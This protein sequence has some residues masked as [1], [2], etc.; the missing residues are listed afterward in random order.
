MP[1][2]GLFDM[3]YKLG[4]LV[5][6]GGLSYAQYFTLYTGLQVMFQARYVTPRILNAESGQVLSADRKIQPTDGDLVIRAPVFSTQVAYAGHP[7]FVFGGDG[8]PHPREGS[9]TMTRIS[10]PENKQMQNERDGEQASGGTTSQNRPN[11][12]TPTTT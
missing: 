7:L 11:H 6:F 9:V 2:L 3:K 1:K 12:R 4:N 10:V 8:K 5:L